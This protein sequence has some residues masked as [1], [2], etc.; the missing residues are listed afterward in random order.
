MPDVPAGYFF[1]R[2]LAIATPAAPSTAAPAMTAA[3]PFRVS[4][5]DAAGLVSFQRLSASSVPAA[6]AAVAPALTPAT[7]A[8]FATLPIRTAAS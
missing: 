3:T 2:D 5:F 1:R 4:F 8:D 7:V 6:I